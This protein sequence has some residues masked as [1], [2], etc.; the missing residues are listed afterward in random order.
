MSSLVPPLARVRT[1][2]WLAG[3]SLR[4]PSRSTSRT[5]GPHRKDLNLPLST[6]T[7]QDGVLVPPLA[8][9]VST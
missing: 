9:S 4:R 7:R 2:A 6:D 1:R 3:I 8:P 5:I